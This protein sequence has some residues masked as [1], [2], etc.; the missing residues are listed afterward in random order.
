MAAPSSSGAA[1]QDD[2]EKFVV[3]ES[4]ENALVGYLSFVVVLDDDNGITADWKC[5]EYVEASI[6]LW[7]LR[8][9]YYMLHKD[10]TLIASWLLQHWSQL[11]ALFGRVGLNMDSHILMSRRQCKCRDVS[12]TIYHRKE[13]SVTT[14]GL[15]CQEDVDTP[16][17]VCCHCKEV[18]AGMCGVSL[19]SRVATVLS[20]ALHASNHCATLRAWCGRAFPWLGQRIARALDCVALKRNPLKTNLLEGPKKK[21]RLDEDFVKALVFATQEPGNAGAAKTGL[22]QL[23]T[24]ALVLLKS[25]LTRKWLSAILRVGA[26]L[27]RLSGASASSTPL[28][29]ATQR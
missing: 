8:R 9:V 19:Q 22:G 28:A 2:A 5:W 27:K 29:S 14:F 3:Q 26:T 24:S 15:L 12:P 16:N 25:G 13:A 17:D 11:N 6:V 21:R 23:A 4:D 20:R 10:T 18:V 7:E 1:L